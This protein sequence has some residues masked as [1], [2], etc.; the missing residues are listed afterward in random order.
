MNFI[1]QLQADNK[2]LKEK[3][4]SALVEINTFIIFLNS[5]KF[6]GT[7]GGERKDWISTGDVIRQMQEI[8]QLLPAENELEI[9][10]KKPK[11]N[12]QGTFH[13]EGCPLRIN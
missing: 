11:C 5:N 3:I 7:E 4:S 13:D 12:C 2:E 8:K 9:T 6:R 10:E 1:K